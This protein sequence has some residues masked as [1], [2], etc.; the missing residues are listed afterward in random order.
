MGLCGCEGIG[1][2]LMRVQIHFK[3]DM[4]QPAGGWIAASTHSSTNGTA[5]AHTTPVCHGLPLSLQLI[6]AAHDASVVAVDR[7][8]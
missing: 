4:A 2:L 5:S 6:V 7:C 8:G 3:G 1:G